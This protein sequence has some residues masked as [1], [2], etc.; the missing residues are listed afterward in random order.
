[1][2]LPVFLLLWRLKNSMS[3]HWWKTHKKWQSASIVSNPAVHSS[4]VIW[5]IFLATAGIAAYLFFAQQRGLLI[6]YHHQSYVNITLLLLVIIPVSV[7]IYAIKK[8]RKGFASDD[9]YFVMKPFPA[10][11]GNTFAGHITILRP[12]KTT[13]M[14]AELR[15]KKHNTPAHMAATEQNTNAV[16]KTTLIWTMP[17][18]VKVGTLPK[19]AQLLIEARLPDQAPVSESP[20][21]PEYHAW[22]L[23]VFSDDHSFARTWEVPVVETT[24]KTDKTV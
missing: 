12:V 18:T 8:T 23:V 24:P 19:G 22:E 1:M 16:V 5:I 21:N 17:V 6:Q 11:I 3:K 14:M 10:V 7:L 13:T 2:Y 15:L 4:L 9:I 20:D